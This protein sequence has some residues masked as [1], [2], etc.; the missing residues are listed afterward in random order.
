MKR[1]FFWLLVLLA[2]AY[3]GSAA[4][5]ICHDRRELKMGRADW[6]ERP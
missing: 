4:W 6:S 5:V 2:L 3:I 1:V